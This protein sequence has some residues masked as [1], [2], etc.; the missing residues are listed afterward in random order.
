M[1]FAEKTLRNLISGLGIQPDQIVTGLNF[2]IG[3]TQAIKVD[4]ESYKAG[5][6]AFVP[7]VT[8]F[9]D[10]TDARLDA[11][12]NMCGQILMRLPPPRISETIEAEP[13]MLNGVHHDV[14]E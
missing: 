2:V 1:N 5:V 10:R 4:R 6:A 14:G 7:L 13:P 12:E 3:E 8:Q 11:I 9:M